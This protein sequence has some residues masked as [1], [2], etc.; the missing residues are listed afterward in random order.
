MINLVKLSEYS[1][2]HYQNTSDYVQKRPACCAKEE[3]KV[4]R[5][6]KIFTDL[7][8]QVMVHSHCPRT[9][10]RQIQRSIEMAYIELYKGIYTVTDAIDYF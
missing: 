1:R 2:L 6:E 7:R 10:P 3:E 9:R 4:D 5:K 8:Q